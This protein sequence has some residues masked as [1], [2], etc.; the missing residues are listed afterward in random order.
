MPQQYCCSATCMFL[1]FYKGWVHGLGFKYIV[2][3]VKVGE[4][5]WG[6]TVHP[7]AFMYCKS[8]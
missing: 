4:A 1:S 6:S 5:P 3:T 8:D 2:Y 7:S